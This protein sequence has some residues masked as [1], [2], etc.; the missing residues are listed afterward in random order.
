MECCAVLLKYGWAVIRTTQVTQNISHA[1]P[2]GKAFPEPTW[3]YLCC[4][5]LGRGLTSENEEPSNSSELSAVFQPSQGRGCW[6]LFHT[7]FKGSHNPDV[8]HSTEGVCKRLS[9]RH[10]SMVMKFQAFGNSRKP[11]SWIVHLGDNAAHG[12][13]L[14]KRTEAPTPTDDNEDTGKWWPSLP[15]TAALFVRD[16]EGQGSAPYYHDSEES[17]KLEALSSHLQTSGSLVKASPF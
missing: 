4:I 5:T 3:D 13:I 11:N 16:V 2:M 15:R 6:G 12:S 8:S 17:T 14:T 1:L 9:T 7:D 10:T